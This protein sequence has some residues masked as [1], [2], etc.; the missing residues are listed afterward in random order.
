[1]HYRGDFT[2]VK[3]FIEDD[4]EVDFSSPLNFAKSFIVMVLTAPFKLITTISAKF[5]YL[6]KKAIE[7]MLLNSTIIGAV[8]TFLNAV[9]L[10]YFGKLSLFLGKFPLIIMIIGTVILAVLYVMVSIGNFTVY[11]QFGELFPNEDE[12]VISASEQNIEPIQSQPEVQQEELQEMQS[13]TE[14]SE[15]FEEFDT[16]LEVLSSSA[17]ETQQ[18]VQQVS[19]NQQRPSSKVVQASQATDNLNLPDLKKTDKVS[20]VGNFV[21]TKMDGESN[22]RFKRALQSSLESS[23]FLSEALLV[24]FV[25][26]EEIADTANLEVLGIGVIP[27]TFKALI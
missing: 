20:R 1:M 2:I 12:T 26:D 10:M 22:N 15:Q 19:Q 6:P 25:E 21:G 3:K 4:F 27:N 17:S 13:S 9:F 5:F 11:V 24:K 7:R 18:Q 16:D 8:I 14:F 23:E